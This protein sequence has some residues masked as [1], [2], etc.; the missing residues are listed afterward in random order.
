MV[1]ATNY[2]YQ[3]GEEIW[4]RSGQRLTVHLTPGT[5]GYVGTKAVDEASVVPPEEQIKYKSGVLEWSW[6]VALSYK[7]FVT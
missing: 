6:H 2:H 4:C 1:R 7:A 3:F 5:P